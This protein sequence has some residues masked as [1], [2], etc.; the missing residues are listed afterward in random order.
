[1]TWS[2]GLG[3][4]QS[5]L[6]IRGFSYTQES[7]SSFHTLNLGG[8]APC[9]VQDHVACCLLTGHGAA[10]GRQHHPPRLIRLCLAPAAGQAADHRCAPE[11]P[12]LPAGPAAPDPAT[13]LPLLVRSCECHGATLHISSPSCCWWLSPE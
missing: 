9:A 4:G 11:L 2:S 10:N 12:Q 6:V 8:T 13:H 1:M 3:F 7:I 5:V